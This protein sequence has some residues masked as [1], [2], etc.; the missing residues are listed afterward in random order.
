MVEFL[1]MFLPGREGRAG[2]PLGVNVQSDHGQE[3]GVAT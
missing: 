1:V 2:D 3:E